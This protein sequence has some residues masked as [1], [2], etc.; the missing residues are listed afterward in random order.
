MS[1][2]GR[3]GATQGGGERTASRRCRRP[4]R[5]WRS[6]PPQLALAQYKE[7]PPERGEFGYAH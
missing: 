6:R 1:L 2:I 3:A 4:S 7:A 5:R